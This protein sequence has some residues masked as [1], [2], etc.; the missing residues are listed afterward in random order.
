MKTSFLTALV[1]LLIVTS[2]SFKAVAQVSLQSLTSSDNLNPWKESQMIEPV[3]LVAILKDGSTVKPVIFNIGAVEDI[4][5]AKHIG[6]VKEVKNLEKLTGALSAIPKNTL[7]I[8]YCGC[9]PFVK[10]PNVRPVFSELNKLGF[11][12]IRI[13]DLPVNLKTNWIN[14][15]YPLAVN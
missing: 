6:P 12:N 8:I 9:C 1:Y 13:L 3:Q 4:M 11:N 15:G 2:T 7:I 10:C 5:G 14:K